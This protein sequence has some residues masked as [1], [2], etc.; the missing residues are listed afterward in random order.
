MDVTWVM[1]LGNLERRND[2]GQELR[3]FGDENGGGEHGPKD[4]GWVDGCKILSRD[5]GLAGVSAERF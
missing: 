1:E 2:D 4:D 5:T 3:H